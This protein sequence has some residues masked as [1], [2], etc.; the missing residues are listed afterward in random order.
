MDI[1]FGVENYFVLELESTALYEFPFVTAR[2][3]HKLGGLKQHRFVVSCF[4][5]LKVLKPRCQQG[6][7]SSRDPRGAPVSLLS[8]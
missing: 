2:N 6:C 1:H 8:P 7:A 5:R 4:W 3:S